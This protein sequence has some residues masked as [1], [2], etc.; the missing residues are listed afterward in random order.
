MRKRSLIVGVAFLDVGVIVACHLLG[1]KHLAFDGVVG[2]DIVRAATSLIGKVNYLVGTFGFV[3]QCYVHHT[4]ALSAYN[5]FT[6]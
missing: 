6:R 4:V 3:G 2:V 1:G 5:T